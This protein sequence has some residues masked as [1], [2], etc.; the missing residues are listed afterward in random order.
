M[1]VTLFIPVH[2]LLVCDVSSQWIKAGSRYVKEWLAFA[3]LSA[4]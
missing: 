1:S 2:A 3:V 4:P